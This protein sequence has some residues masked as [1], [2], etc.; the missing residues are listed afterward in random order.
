MNRRP[1]PEVRTVKRRDTGSGKDSVSIGCRYLHQAM[2]RPG[3]F[4]V[5]P[6]CVHLIEC[7]DRWQG[8]DDDWKDA[9]DA[10]RYALVMRIFR[11]RQAF[12][13]V[14]IRLY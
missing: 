4:T 12:K 9:I 10:L 11:G 13:N 1:H 7:L 6:R 14:P 5:A 3:G 2:L 8:A